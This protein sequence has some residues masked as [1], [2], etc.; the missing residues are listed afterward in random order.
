M[1]NKGEGRLTTLCGLPMC[2]WE[3]FIGE[4]LLTWIICV[5]VCVCACDVYILFALQCMDKYIYTVYISILVLKTAKMRHKGHLSSRMDRRHERQTEQC[6]H[7]RTIT[8]LGRSK[9][10]MHSSSGRAEVEFEKMT[11]SKAQQGLVI[12]IYIYSHISHPMVAKFQVQPPPLFQR[13][14]GFCERHHLWAP[15]AAWLLL[16]GH[17]RALHGL[18]P[19]FTLLVSLKSSQGLRR[20]IQE[21]Q[22]T[23]KNQTKKYPRRGKLDTERQW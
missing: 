12:Y 17:H 2:L 3:H 8:F 15:L 7:G 19:Y 4:F 21:L 6:R 18:Q 13:F 1:I 5:C 16:V 22:E 20:W 11:N 9:H 10:T 23:T 14:P